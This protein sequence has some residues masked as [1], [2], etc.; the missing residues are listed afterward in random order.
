MTL[1]TEDFL[2]RL[3]RHVPPPKTRVVRCYGLYHHSHGD[4]LAT[5]RTQ[6]GQPLVVV[7]TKLDWQSVCAQRGEAH[8]ERCPSCGVLLVCTV[9]LPRAG[10]P[11]LLGEEQAA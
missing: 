6:L 5:C 2:Q 4:A 7:A 9:V 11:P 3:L 8:P 1:S 10:S